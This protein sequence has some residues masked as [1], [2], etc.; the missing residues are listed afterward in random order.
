MNASTLCTSTDS[1]SFKKYPPLA[2]HP[3]FPQIEEDAF[4]ASE[5]DLSHRR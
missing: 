3:I 1:H 4:L 2:L 5:A